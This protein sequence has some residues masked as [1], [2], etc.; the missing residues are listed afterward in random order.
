MKVSILLSEHKNKNEIASFLSDIRKLLP[1]DCK[2][3]D[4]NYY[5]DGLHDEL[6]FEIFGDGHESVVY[7][8]LV[9]NMLN[10]SIWIFVE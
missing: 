3:G 5:V 4:V 9:A 7:I 10:P 6:V 8:G 2:L 1:T